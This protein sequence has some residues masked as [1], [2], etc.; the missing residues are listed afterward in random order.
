MAGAGRSKLMDPRVFLQERVQLFDARLDPGDCRRLL[1]F[2]NVRFG[3]RFARL[4]HFELPLKRRA[5]LYP[6][7]D[8]FMDDYHQIAPRLELSATISDDGGGDGDGAKERPPR[9]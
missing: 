9:L 2:G 5:D 4:E 3:R 8:Q 1:V 7:L 6:V